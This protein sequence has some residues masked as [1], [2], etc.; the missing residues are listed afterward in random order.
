MST[1]ALEANFRRLAAR[2]GPARRPWRWSRPTPTATAPSGWRG[3]SPPPGSTGSAWPSL[4]EGAE[5]RAAGIGVP[6]LVLGGPASRQFALA[7]A[8]RLTPAVSSLAELALWR[9]GRG[10]G[11]VARRRSTSRWTPAWGGSASPPR[12]RCRALWRL[13]AHAAASSWP[14]CCPTSPTADDLAEP[15][16]TRARSGRFAGCSPCGRGRSGGRRDPH[17][18]QRRRRSTGR[19]GAAHPGPPGLALYGLDPAGGAGRD[20]GRGLGR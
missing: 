11:G 20:R 4:E 3:A 9:D 17:G 8:Y 10:A 1:C 16:A 5:L 12:R 13:R 15:G 7:L 19:G 18:Q 2:L 14:A 6:I